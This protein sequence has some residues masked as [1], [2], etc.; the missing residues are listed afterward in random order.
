MNKNSY[1]GNIN[2]FPKPLKTAGK[3]RVNKNFNILHLNIQ[4]LR[5]K[6]NELNAFLSDNN[7]DVICLNEHWLLND[8]VEYVIV[9]DYNLVSW[10]CR[11]NTIHGGIAIYCLKEYNCSS[12][13]EI[14]KLS[15][16]VHCEL[17]A[18]VC[19][20]NFHILTVYRSPS[21]NFNIFLEQL[22]HALD[23]LTEK[24]KKI[25]VTGD[26]NVHFHNPDKN[27]LSLVNLFTSYG[28]LALNKSATRNDSCLDNIFINFSQSTC[29]T[30]TID[31]RLSDHFGIT[32][33]IHDIKPQK[34][35]Q[36]VNFRPVTDTGLF[37]LNDYLK[38]CDWRFINDPSINIDDKFEIFLNIISSTL[39]SVF[40]EKS[41]IFTSGTANKIHWFTDELRQMRESLNLLLDLH[42]MNPTSNLKSLINTKKSLYRS[43]L[44]RAK[45]NAH[46]KYISQSKNP[47]KAMWNIINNNKPQ[48]CNSYKNSS[49]LPTSRDFNIYFGSVA[50]NIINTLPSP[51]KHF[52]QYLKNTNVD[53]LNN[54]F[55]FSEVSYLQILDI[56]NN[57]KRTNSKDPYNINLKILNSIKYII[58]IPLTK[59]I[60]QCIKYNVFPNILK[61]SKVI[62]IHKKGNTDEPANYRPISIIPVFAK[63]FEIVLKLQ[64]TT[65]FENS[66]LFNNSQFGFRKRMSTTLAINTLTNIIN[67]GYEH[68]EFLYAVFLDLSKAFDCVS[69]DILIQKLSYYNFSNNS[70]KLLTSYLEE[71][72]QFVNYHNINS[73]L[74]NVK[75]GVPQGSVLGPTLFII[76]INDLPD[77]TGL[78]QSVL[79]ADDTTLIYKNRDI[80]VLTSSVRET[81]STIHDW[82]SSNRLMLNESKTDTIIF[83]LRHSTLNDISTTDCV[84]F[85][86]VYLDNKLTWEKHANN[87][88]NKVSKHIFL[89][90]GLA[91]TV[92]QT[93][94][95]TAYY[96]LIHSQIT[97]A[98]L[99]WGHSP[100]AATVF[101][102]QR[103]AIRVIAG[104]GYRDDCRDA[105]K[106]LKV[107]TLCSIYVLQCLL[108]VKEN[109]SK[110]IKR[111]TIHLYHTRNSNKLQTDFLRL[112]KTRDGAGYYGIKFFNLLPYEIQKLNYKHFK[113]V[114]KKF[115]TD[116]AFYDINDFTN[117]DFSTMCV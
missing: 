100:H 54:E 49:A 48:T 59:L 84:K 71:R 15:V 75:F 21:G 6:I 110:Y 103:R 94:L 16:E 93:T 102:I 65:Y 111:D 39:E 106:N 51:N 20:G 5:N 57:L 47:N 26:F 114:V 82:F 107:L 45:R 90:R 64:I 44:N 40:P 23:I 117:A 46:D 112:T 1:E 2:I 79:F 96:G 72:T 76:F 74:I 29:T 89:L 36:R 97:Y 17:A 37:Q 41:K 80:N 25:I 83:S 108:H 9:S 4:C 95:L 55:N 69:H 78:A 56:I 85:L 14:N 81:Q 19:G 18:V 8:E 35:S 115:L 10:F 53:S 12:I 31:P 62:P 32:L 99:V 91:K 30:N 38:G 88:C 113:T 87:I 70:Q 77:N 3:N 27:V 98:I 7:F 52:T 13:L 109:E 73:S 68:G 92:S 34:S 58:L 86:G 22:A 11:R 61:V 101:A 60:N 116:N 42:R 105:F 63:I 66:N 50:E 28:F 67:G 104:L 24:Y 33:S 43:E